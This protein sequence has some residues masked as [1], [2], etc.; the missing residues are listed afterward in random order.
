MN[1]SSN[2]HSKAANSQPGAFPANSWPE[3][4]AAAQR[5][6][7]EFAYRFPTDSRPLGGKFSVEENA[8]RLLRFFYFERRLAQAI[9]AWTLA[10]PEF[11]VKLESGR[12][13][14]YHADAANG[15]R[16]RLREQEQGF[17][18]IDGFRDAE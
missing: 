17:T 14:F 2:G 5:R 1:Q 13:L 6:K 12:H 8:R 16:D 7:N 10:I 4:R 11:E 15:L 9:G 18:A 3:E